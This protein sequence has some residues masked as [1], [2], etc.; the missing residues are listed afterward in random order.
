[1]CGKTLDQVTNSP[2]AESYQQWNLSEEFT[3]VE[4]SQTNSDHNS[5]DHGTTDEW[6]QQQ[7][8]QWAPR[9]VVSTS[10][11]TPTE[12]KGNSSNSNSST[13]KNA[14]ADLL[15]LLYYHCH[16]K[17]IKDPLIP[18]VA[19]TL[20]SCLTPPNA[21]VV[22]SELIPH[23]M[24]LL[25]LVATATERQEAS[26]IFL[27][28]NFHLLATYH[29]PLLVFHLD[30][31]LPGWFR[32]MMAT[33]P[34]TSN[35]HHTG[36]D[37]NEA[38]KENTHGHGHG[39]NHNNN[40]K[41]HHHAL[42]VPARARKKQGH[43]PPSWFLSHLA[44]G[45]RPESSSSSPTATEAA[46]SHQ[47]ALLLPMDWVL[48]VWDA[49]L[50]SSPST[51]FFLA[52]AVLEQAA[53]ELLLLTGREL[54]RRLEWIWNCT[55]DVFG[56][57][58]DWMK[59]KWWARTVALQQATPNS[60]LETLNTAEDAA[61]QQALL[62]RQERAEQELQARLQAEAAAHR[63]AQERKAEAARERLTRARLVAFYR[64][65]APDK[66][67]NIDKIMQQFAGR[68]EVLD[69][70]LKVKYGE[71]F[72]PALKPKNAQ[73]Q[74][75]NPP[76]SKTTSKLLTTMNQGFR[77]S[78]TA[79]EQHSEDKNDEKLEEDLGLAERVSPLVSAA[80]VLPSVCWSKDAAAAR[81]E[82]SRRRRATHLK[83]LKFYLIDSR[84]EDSVAEQGRFPTAVS[85]SPETMHEPEKLKENEEMFESLRGAVH[86]VIMGEGFSA[87]PELY[88]H[89]LS[90]KLE[91]LMR[92]DDARTNN[93]ALF[94]VKQGFP[95]VSVLSGGF[96]AAHSWL[97][98]DGPSHHLN[99]SAVLIDYDPEGSLFGQLETLHNAS[100]SEK[101]QR[102]MQN[103]LDKSIVVMTKRAAQLERLAEDK[104]V[105]IS[106]RS[107]G[108]SSVLSRMAEEEVPNSNVE[109]DNNPA[110]KEGST[111]V[112]GV[113]E[114]KAEISS[115]I[116]TDTK[117]P[118]ASSKPAETAPSVPVSMN[119]PATSTPTATAASA[120][121]KAAGGG[122]GGVADRLRGLGAVI[123][124]AAK[125]D[126]AQNVAANV[127][128]R[129]PFARFGGGGG[130][131][132]QSA[133]N[134]LN[135]STHSKDSSDGLAVPP[136][137]AT[138]GGGN[139]FG[140][141]GQAFARMR[142][143][144]TVAV[145]SSSSSATK[146][147]QPLD[148][149]GDESITFSSSPDD[150]AAAAATATSDSSPSTSVEASAPAITNDATGANA[151]V[152]RV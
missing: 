86:I 129:N 35:H 132:A 14:E 31:H 69:A 130:S 80:E 75:G 71:G 147:S 9:I 57:G 59:T 97:V 50:T 136:P 150:I 66:E 99:V 144:S 10:L 82:N 29:V 125:S 137:K 30:R 76:M 15:K 107:F 102:K 34:V 37:A 77:L 58:D 60:I 93:C 28:R 72:N 100:A 104:Q 92:Q 123:D 138:G 19:A 98:R 73:Q 85:L 106:F 127:L 103:L 121:P 108:L 22:L 79:E 38:T 44:G 52:L 135:N 139:G 41:H 51:R 141:W 122:G 39:D 53:E 48:R 113:K 54:S 42:T 67:A 25:A 115:S 89:K 12:T 11:T 40:N 18:P 56:D 110:D 95:F 148:D 5:S 152:Q 124:T 2:L 94:F 33:A 131:N 87:L 47:D 142:G 45:D 116:V 13:T 120:A 118:A 114:L 17:Q 61:V 1:V 88:N 3:K 84:P 21:C 91:D 133:S 62:R 36:D 81:G 26:E 143:G 149:P 24:P 105:G 8:R 64:K 46:E 146:A 16:N 140:G 55:G 90:P 23:H 126:M 68:F 20:L 134:S 112:K 63:E 49:T 109:S 128:K 119:A 96:A 145:V 4:S 101:A 27:Y 70:K 78:N 65:H 111:E 6:I 151:N 83:H 7:A 117:E 43:V 74:A 32:P